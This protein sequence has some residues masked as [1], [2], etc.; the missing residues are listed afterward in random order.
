MFR[1]REGATEHDVKNIA[2]NL[3]LFF[4]DVQMTWVESPDG[5]PAHA[6]PGADRGGRLR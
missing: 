3:E 6:G 4:E 1:L 2:A 5:G